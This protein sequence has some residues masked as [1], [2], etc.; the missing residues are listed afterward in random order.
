LPESLVGL[1]R[2]HRRNYLHNLIDHG[3][4]L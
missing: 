3:E 2:P 1:A 4:V